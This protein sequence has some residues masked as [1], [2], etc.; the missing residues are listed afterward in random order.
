MCQISLGDDDKKKQASIEKI[1]FHPLEPAECVGCMSVNKSRLEAQDGLVTKT[2][3]DVAIR[4]GCVRVAFN[5]IS[6]QVVR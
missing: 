3:V 2:S 4:G 6:R 5:R 1:H